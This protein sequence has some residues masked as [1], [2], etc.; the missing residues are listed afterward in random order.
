MTDLFD[1]VYSGR[2]CHHVNCR[3]CRTRSRWIRRKAWRTRKN[4]NRRNHGRKR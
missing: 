1:A 2:H 3:K 4:P